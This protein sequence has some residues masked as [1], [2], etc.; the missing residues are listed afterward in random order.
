MWLETSILL[1]VAFTI[2]VIK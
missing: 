2:F 1:F